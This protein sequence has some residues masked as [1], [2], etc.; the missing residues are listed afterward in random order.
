MTTA[1]GFRV[2][3]AAGLWITVGLTGAAQ[4]VQGPRRPPP[5]R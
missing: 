5:G 1:H 4:A 3:L 2:L